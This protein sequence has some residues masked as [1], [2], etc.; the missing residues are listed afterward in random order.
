MNKKNRNKTE[1]KLIVGLGNIGINYE[2]NRHNI[3]FWFL[4]YIAKNLDCRFTLEK[5][6]CAYLTPTTI[7]KYHI[8]LAKPNTYVNHS[9]FALQ[10]IM[11][12]YRIMPSEFLLVHDD[13]DLALGEVKIKYAGG[14]G[15]HN[16]L[17]H[18]IEMLGSEK[19]YRLRFGIGRPPNNISVSNF[20]LGDFLEKENNVIINTIKNAYSVMSD[21]VA[22][23]M[24]YAMQKL[25][26]K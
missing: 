22:G 9:G 20:V 5:K 25:H 21:L 4:D 17:R 12:F 7:N 1:I 10:K 6:R 24:D 8:H 18:I 13:L 14:H 2:N 11:H 19:F 16:G 26:T 3:G 23:N 15:G